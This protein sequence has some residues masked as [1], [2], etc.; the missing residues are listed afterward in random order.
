MERFA[1]EGNGYPLQCSG[2][3]NPHGRGSL[4]GYSPWGHKGSDMTEQ[5]SIAQ[6]SVLKKKKKEV[7][8]LRV[9]NEGANQAWGR[10]VK[11]RLLH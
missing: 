6:N 5:L 7:E 3:E 2:L 8:A 1:G 10:R 9:L 11:R 4:A